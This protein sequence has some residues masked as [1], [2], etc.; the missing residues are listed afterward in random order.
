MDARRR[1]RI[2]RIVIVGDAPLRRASENQPL[3]INAPVVFSIP[4]PIAIPL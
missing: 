3:A 2:Q 1:V 4:I